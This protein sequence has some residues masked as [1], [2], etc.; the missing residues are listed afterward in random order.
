MTPRNSTRPWSTVEPGMTVNVAGSMD[1]PCPTAT[2]RPSALRVN[3]VSSPVGDTKIHAVRS[4]GRYGGGAENAAITCVSVLP[5]SA[6][7]HVPLTLSDWKSTEPERVSE[8]TAGRK[9]GEIGGLVHSQDPPLTATTRRPSVERP[10]MRTPAA[11]TPPV[12]GLGCSLRQ[13]SPSLDVQL[14]NRPT[15]SWPTATSRSSSSTTT[16]AI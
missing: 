14:A 8:I 5:S 3:A 1:A 2:E 11:G 6:R 9:S 16:S 15:A 12:L 4:L 10:V 13:D 7:S